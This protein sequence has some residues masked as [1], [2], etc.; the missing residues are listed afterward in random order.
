MV[1]LLD[2]PLDLLLLVSGLVRVE[3]R[4]IGRASSSHRLA[5]EVE[6]EELKTSCMCV[7]YVDCCVTRV[8]VV[9]RGSARRLYG[10]FVSRFDGSAGFGDAVSCCFPTFW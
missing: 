6:A 7:L 9:K 5:G 3:Y 8:T 1:C 10:S 4:E 2:A